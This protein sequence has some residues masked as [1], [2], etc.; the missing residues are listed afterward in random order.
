[1][2]F[3]DQWPH[4][5]ARSVTFQVSDHESY[6]IFLTLLSSD[7]M[8]NKRYIQ[9]LKGKHKKPVLGHVTCATTYVVQS[10]AI[11][12]LKFLIFVQ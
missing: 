1:M 5:N 11:A 12:L 7:I 2:D 6:L 8:W 10:S 4:S 9:K 3:G